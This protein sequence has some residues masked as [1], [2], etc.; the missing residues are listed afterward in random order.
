MIHSIVRQSIEIR[1]RFEQVPKIYADSECAAAI[2]IL[3][4]KCGLALPQ[5]RD[6]FKT[7]KS[8]LEEAAA[9]IPETQEI[10]K[11]KQILFPYEPKGPVTDELYE[12]LEE[13]YE[14]T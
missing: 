12:I 9:D 7:M 8:E 4:K 11:L 14:N 5:R 6:D 13:S 10:D 1:L 3:A 2:G